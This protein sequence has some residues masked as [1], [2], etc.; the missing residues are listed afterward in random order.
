MTGRVMFTVDMDRDVNIPLEG[1]N[2]AGSID[3]GHGTEARFESCE[4]GMEI[5]LD[6]LDSFGMKATFFVEGRTSE[7]VDCSRLR[8]HCIGFH[9]YRNGFDALLS[10]EFLDE[11][12]DEL[13]TEKANIDEILVYVAK[14]DRHERHD[15]NDK[16]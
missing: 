5:I 6:V 4:K 14:E 10:T 2:R 9:G 11:V 7:V 3:R 16:V 8:S 15:E 1:T 12:S 13:E